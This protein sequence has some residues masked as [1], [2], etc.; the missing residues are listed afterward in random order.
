VVEVYQR[1]LAS[2]Q[3]SVALDG[4]MIDEATLKRARA[5]LET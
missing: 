2:G 1:A 4:R 3:G 5:I